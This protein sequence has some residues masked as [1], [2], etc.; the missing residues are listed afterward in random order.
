[1]RDAGSDV[2]PSP[3]N[4]VRDVN[5]THQPEAEQPDDELSAELDSKYDEYIQEGKLYSFEKSDDKLEDEEENPYQHYIDEGEVNERPPE[6]LTDTEKANLKEETG[7]S[8]EVVN[9]M[10][11]P[12]EAAIYKNANLKEAEID[13]RPCLIRE[14]I[15]MDQKDE[16]GRTNR[17]RMENGNAPLTASGETVELHHIGQRQDSPLAELTTQEHRGKGNDAVMH[18]KNVQSEI[19]R[20]AFATERKHHWESRAE[21]A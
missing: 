15:P 14:D 7:W 9:S 20:S 4:D 1:M 2:S 10:R 21:S 6:G 11:S 19:D 12:E 13:G 16:F 8:D 5:E 17:Q 18:D 3:E